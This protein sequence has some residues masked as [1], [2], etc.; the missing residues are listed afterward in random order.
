MA[1]LGAFADAL[2]AVV[3]DRRAE[4]GTA[5]VYA[6]ACRFGA[7]DVAARRVDGSV[8]S[9]CVSPAIG[10]YCGDGA[11]Y[12][13]YESA[14]I[15]AKNRTLRARRE[16]TLAR[17]VEVRFANDA[18]P[19]WVG[20]ALPRGNPLAVAPRADGVVVHAAMGPWRAA[21]VPRGGVRGDAAT[22]AGAL[23]FFDPNPNATEDGAGA[24]VLGS[25]EEKDAAEKEKDATRIA[26][27]VRFPTGHPARADGA[28]TPEDL[29]GLDSAASGGERSN[30]RSLR[31]V[32]SSAL[33]C[34]AP[35]W[36]PAAPGLA[37]GA[38]SS[39]TRA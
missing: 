33:P 1:T 13:S 31:G 29:A 7:V 8:A 6:P 12:S 20:A 4:N 37:S 27:R 39:S 24:G 2:G 9:A 28:Y 11:A 21:G 38:S 5:S 16:V 3:S 14:H 23:A 32:L 30:Q 35:A 10:G 17:R 19:G 25:G 34:E 26:C 15:G 36:G 18:R 22:V